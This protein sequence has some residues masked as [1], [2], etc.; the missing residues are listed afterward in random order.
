MISREV[1]EGHEALDDPFQSKGIQYPAHGKSQIK[2]EFTF[3]QNLL[4]IDKR[5]KNTSLT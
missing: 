1:G 4:L 5:F 3:H 2:I